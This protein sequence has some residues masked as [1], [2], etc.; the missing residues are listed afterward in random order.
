MR[1][2]E[3]EDEN[4]DEDEDEDADPSTEEDPTQEKESKKGERK[5]DFKA[6]TDE[7]RLTTSPLVKGFDLK[8]K[9]WCTYI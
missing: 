5:E 4:E 8:A 6:L 2:S 7:E 1:S 9:E 3:D